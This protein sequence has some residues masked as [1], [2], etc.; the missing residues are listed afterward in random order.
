VIVS[1][2]FKKTGVVVSSGYV[3]TNSSGTACHFPLSGE[4]NSTFVICEEN[5]SWTWEFKDSA[6]NIGTAT[7]MVDWIDK[8]AP[9]M[10]KVEYSPSSLTS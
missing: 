7:A 5:G 2:S 3:S 8:E 1:V 6:G 4:Y 9:E 10:V